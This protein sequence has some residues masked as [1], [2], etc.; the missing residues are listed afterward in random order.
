MLAPAAFFLLQ[1]AQVVVALVPAAPLT[2]AGVAAFGPWV[3]FAIALSGAVAGSLAALLLGRRFGRPMVA[4][5][6]GKKALEGN[7]GTIGGADG[8]W[9]LPLLFLPLPVGG[10]AVCAV[11]GL[12]PISLRR[13]LVLVA[14][15]RLPNTALNVLLGSGLASGS[16][17]LLVGG[18]AAQALLVGAALLYMRRRRRRR[19]AAAEARTGQIKEMEACKGMV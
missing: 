19:A 8:L 17:A 9:I 1:A 2:L 5:L 6:A 4:R 12:S 18:V 3:G 16:A 7:A 13:F 14:V 10:D 15:G 11:A